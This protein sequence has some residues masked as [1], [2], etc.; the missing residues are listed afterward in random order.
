MA[1]CWRLAADGDLQDL[2]AAQRVR[3]VAEGRFLVGE[4]PFGRELGL[5]GLCA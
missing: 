3:C 5:H 2:I 1:D 4:G